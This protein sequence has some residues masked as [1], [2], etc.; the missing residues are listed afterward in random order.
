MNRLERSLRRLVSD[1]R[2]I[3]CDYALVGGLAVSV[4]AE[5]RLTRDV[6]VVVSVVDDQAAEEVVRTLAGVGYH[7]TAVMEQEAIGR[8]ATVRLERMD[9]PS[10][11]VV[12]LLFASSGIEPEIVAA[13][14]LME[15]LTGLTLP[16]AS[17]GHLIAM[18]LLARDD[19]RRPT[20]ADDL[21]ALSEVAQPSD[22]DVAANAVRAITARG[23]HRG[24]DLSA[25]LDELRRSG[26]YPA[27][28]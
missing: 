6:D 23:F 17:T 27:D 7:P 10:G 21:R 19:R 20:D 8:L 4:R 5:P 13:A 9:E 2:A 1:L 14:D 28:P 11:F 16:V 15:V 12:D 26:A 24:R 25:A 18:K 3:G 22:W